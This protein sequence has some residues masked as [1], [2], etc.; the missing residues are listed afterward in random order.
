[1]V[2]IK[3]FKNIQLIVIKQKASIPDH[4][5]LVYFSTK[6]QQDSPFSLTINFIQTL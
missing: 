2:L 6:Y 5:I 3:K 1:M 4:T